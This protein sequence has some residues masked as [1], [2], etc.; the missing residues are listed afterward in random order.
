MTG[1]TG[2]SGC[3]HGSRLDSGTLAVPDLL[4]CLRGNVE[5]VTNDAEVRDLEDRCLVVL[6]DRNDGLGGLHTSLVLDS[7]GDTQRDV[8]VRGHG[9]TGLADL[10][11]ARVVVCVNCST[12][13]TNG[14]AE[15]VRQRLDDVGE[16]LG[17]THATATGDDDLRLSQ[18]RTVAGL[19]RSEAGDLHSGRACTRQLDCLDL[20]GS[21]LRLRIDGAGLPG[22]DRCHACGTGV[23]DV[24][25]TEDRLLSVALGIDLGDAVDRT[26]AHASGHATSNLV[27]GSGS[28]DQD[29][30]LQVGGEPGEGIDGRGDEQGVSIVGLGSV[31]GLCA[32]SSQL[33]LQTL[34]GARLA[35][36]DGADL[37]EY[38]TSGDELA[39]GV[40]QLTF[41][42]INQY[43]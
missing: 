1:N 38:A 30:N 6:V 33:G 15:R 26:G 41:N 32:G 9:D 23:D 24:L 12:R 5:E 2:F 13:C 28:R 35:N 27:A 25:A 37:A 3:T 36:N 29:R 14:T 17:A 40:L 4:G 19:G 22:E 8:Q 34:S 20:T 43:Q 39:S 21:V 31:D 42:V 10:E 16:A 7:T 18:V 11:L